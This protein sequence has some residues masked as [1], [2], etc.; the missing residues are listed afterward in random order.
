MKKYSGSA[1]VIIIIVLVVALVGTLGFVF[2][3]NFMKESPNT[4]ST[5]KTETNTTLQKTDTVAVNPYENWKT[6]DSTQ[7]GYT[8]KYPHDWVV[9][10]ETDQD[11][12]YIRNFDPTSRPGSEQGYPEGYINLRVDKLND[13]S[14]FM[15]AYG[16]STQQW[17]ENLGVLEV[18]NGV[19]SFMP[20]DVSKIT[21]NGMDAK[22]VKLA[23]T[24]T[25][26]NIYLM[27]NS[28]LY[29]MILYPYGGTSNKNVTLIIDSFT[30]K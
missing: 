26:E 7:D 3:Q 16:M 27:K 20:E 8:I 6:Y 21:V 4:S 17:Y 25:N 19:G 15:A 22:T 24:E 10:P 12:V 11:G 14:D 1:H 23:F 2:W 9:V 29:R 28:M 13:D 18:Q 5:T 30:I